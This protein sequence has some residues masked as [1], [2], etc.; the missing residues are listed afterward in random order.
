LVDEIIDRFRI[1]VEG[2]DRRKEDRSHSTGLK[3]QFQMTLM[4][5]GLTHHQDE[6]SCF[7]E[8]DVGSPG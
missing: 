2:W 3:H 4:K 1:V 7:L 8:S 6:F 5:R